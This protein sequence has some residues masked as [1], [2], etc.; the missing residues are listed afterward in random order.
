MP[1]SVKTKSVSGHG[2]DRPL[3]IGLLFDREED[4][5]EVT[6]PAD[7]FAEFEPESTIRAMEKAVYRAGHRPLRIGSPRKMLYDIPETG[8]DLIWNIAEGYGTRNR[9]AWAPVLC[10]LHGIP[11]LGSDALT[12][13]VALD[14]ALT[15]HLARSLDIPTPDWQVVTSAVQAPALPWPV[16]LKPRYE[17]TAKGISERSIVHNRQ[18]FRRESQRLLDLYEQDVLAECFMEGPEFTCAMAGSP[19][20][21]LPVLERSLHDSGIGSHAMANRGDRLGHA[22]TSDLEETISRW[23][24]TL[25]RFLGVLDFARLDFKMTA[26]GELMF[27][28]INPLPT[29]GIDSTFAILAE[30]EGIPYTEYLAGILNASV[31][32]LQDQK[33]LPRK[34]SKTIG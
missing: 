28:E 8:P 30:M 15:K 3:S 12:L 31:R 34:S 11:F 10:E 25:C 16:F 4:Y 32:R 23:S 22:L 7:R 21:P 18:E 19:L 14:K 27:L 13:S 2:L 29:F 20:K 17:G 5:A 24:G 26:G 6:G 9:E 33:L 1:A